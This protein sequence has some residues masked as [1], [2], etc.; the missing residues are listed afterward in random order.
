MEFLFTANHEHTE[1]KKWCEENN[2]NFSYLKWNDN[3]S[4]QR[5]FNFNQAK[6]Y[7][8]VLWGGF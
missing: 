3:F 7:D 5:N 8:F 4:E 2:L 1:T 6:G